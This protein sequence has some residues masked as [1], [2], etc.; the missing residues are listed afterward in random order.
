M[1][2]KHIAIAAIIAALYVVLTL[3]LGPLATSNFINVRPAEALT[4]LPLLSPAAIPGLFIG[5]LI[6]NIP[7]AFGILDILLGSLV[8]LVAA[9][10]TKLVKNV[11]IGGVFPVL[12]NAIFLPIIFISMGAEDLYFVL[13]LSILITQIV[14]VYGLGIPLYY[15]CKKK[16]LFEKLD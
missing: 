15:F 12:L 6:S 5:C 1:K 14:W 4:L 16:K 2:T 3:P 13:F 9:V 10:L 7:S 8:T 11:W